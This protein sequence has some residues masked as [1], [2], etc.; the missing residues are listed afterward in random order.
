[1]ERQIAP[2]ITNAATPRGRLSLTPGLLGNSDVSVRDRVN[3]IQGGQPGSSTARGVGKVPGNVTERPQTSEPK[4]GIG[5]EG[6]LDAEKN[7]VITSINPGS[8]AEQQLKTGDIITQIDFKRAS[9]F[10]DIADV[11]KYLRG[12]KD[13]SVIIYIRTG[14]GGHTSKRPKAVQL[15][16]TIPIPRPRQ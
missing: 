4:Y 1:M 6:V 2:A 8:P 10:T 14:E 5:I 15:K 11:A 16:R 12:T 7:I 13:T 3:A 9:E